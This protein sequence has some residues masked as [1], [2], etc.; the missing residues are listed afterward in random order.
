M[1]YTVLQRIALTLLT[2]GLTG[3]SFVLTKM[4]LGAGVDQITVSFVQLAGASAVLLT[5]LRFRGTAPTLN[6]GV[7][8][9]FS[10]ASLI[11]LAAGPLLGNWVLGRIPAAIFTVV[12]TFSPMFTTLLTALIER[13]LPSINALIGVLLGLSGALLVLLPRVRVAPHGEAFA[14]CLA[15]G[16][17][18]LLA[19]GNIYRSR[20]WPPQLAPAAASAGALAVQGVLLAP[21]FAVRPHVAAATIWSAAPLFALSILVTVAA[22]VS[23]STLQRVAGA[24]AYSQIGYVIALTGVV[25][26]TILFHESLD[27]T[28]WP[29]LALVFAGIVLT[30]RAWRPAHA[31]PLVPLTFRRSD[32]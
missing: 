14:L 2:G 10:I 18:M 22:N 29:A 11:A 25:A 16:V 24:T 20:Y 26:G 3:T 13:R 17:P 31:V 5:A 30:N 4:L 8:R 15:L 12:V 9:Y 23:G 19:V 32:S 6:G 1:N 21:V 27:A 28:F 7:L